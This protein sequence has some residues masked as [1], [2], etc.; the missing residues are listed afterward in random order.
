MVHRLHQTSKKPMG[1]KKSLRTP[2]LG[3]TL[4]FHHFQSFYFFISALHMGHAA[5]GF[6]HTIFLIEKNIYKNH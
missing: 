4:S 5:L 2:P 3:V 6:T 1:P